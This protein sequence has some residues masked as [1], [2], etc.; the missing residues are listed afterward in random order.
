MSTTYQLTL[1]TKEASCLLTFYYNGKARVMIIDNVE[2]N[3][4]FRGKGYGTELI[5]EA[6]ETAKDENV[7]SVELQVN[8][9]NEV[10]KRL[11]QK[12]GFEKTNKEYYRLILNHFK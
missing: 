8:S 10:A 2:V 9:D 6:I 3:E 7:D 4:K 5:K 1:Y 11:Y 12:S